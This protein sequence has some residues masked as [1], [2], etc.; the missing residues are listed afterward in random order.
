[1]KD[2]G[3]TPAT[4]LA[5]LGRKPARYHGVVN[6]PVFHASTV[7]YETLEDFEKRRGVDNVVCPVRDVGGQRVEP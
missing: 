4:K 3:K 5:H 6:M 7:L 1:M 2:K